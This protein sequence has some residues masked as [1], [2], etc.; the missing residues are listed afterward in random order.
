MLTMF[1]FI[2][3]EHRECF[4][5]CEEFGKTP[6]E[7]LFSSYCAVTFGSETLFCK[8]MV[9]R[10]QNQNTEWNLSAFSLMFLNRDGP[11]CLA[12]W[13]IKFSRRETPHPARDSEC[14]QLSIFMSFGTIDIN[15]V[16]SLNF[17]FK[18]S[19]CPVLEQSECS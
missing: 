4:P 10:L 14:Q 19:G 5:W 18:N 1:S 11:D 7:F 15:C 8:H 13:I 2:K 3:K 17:N 16:M 9:P 6:L 12:H